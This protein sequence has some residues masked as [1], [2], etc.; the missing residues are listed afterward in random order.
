MKDAFNQFVY[1]YERTRKMITKQENGLS[2]F[3]YNY[4]EGIQEKRLS[5]FF[6]SLRIKIVSYLQHVYKHAYWLDMHEIIQVEMRF[7]TQTCLFLFI[8]VL[9]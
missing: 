5:I 8:S 1:V 6:I 3:I 7:S 2:C 4:I 9:V